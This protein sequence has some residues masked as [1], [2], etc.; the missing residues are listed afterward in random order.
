MEGYSAP[1]SVHSFSVHSFEGIK[2]L[3]RIVVKYYPFG[4]PDQ[5][6]CPE[7]DYK[8]D[9]HAVDAAG[10]KEPVE[11]FCPYCRIP[12]GV[13]SSSLKEVPVVYYP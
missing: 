7:C 3:G 4:S 9:S 2:R 1:R 10:T 12:I 6:T 11:F 8:A 5:L 13:A